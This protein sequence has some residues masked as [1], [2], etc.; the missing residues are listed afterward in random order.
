MAPL[1]DLRLESPP[2]SVDPGDG[3][4]GRRAHLRAGLPALVAVGLML[5]WAIQNGGFDASTWYWGALRPAGHVH[6]GVRR[7]CSA[8]I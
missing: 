4:A 2:T 1:S 3:P 8:A 7:A 5:V 6:R